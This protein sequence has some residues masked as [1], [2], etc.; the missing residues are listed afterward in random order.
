MRFRRARF[1]TPAL[2]AAHEEAR[3]AVPAIGYPIP[4]AVTAVLV[5]IA[6]YLALFL[7]PRPLC[8]AAFRV[9]RFR[10]TKRLIPS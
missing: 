6:G 8:R 4:Y 10:Q 9:L 3:S 7:W 5:L 1:S 2:R